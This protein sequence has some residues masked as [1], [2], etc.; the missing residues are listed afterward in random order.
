MIPESVRAS[1]I[2]GYAQQLHGSRRGSEPIESIWPPCGGNRFPV[3]E[4]PMFRLKSIRFISA[5]AALAMVVTSGCARL[6]PAGLA[7]LKP[8]LAEAV[9]PDRG[10][11]YV[12]FKISWPAES[13][14]PFWHLDALLAHKVAS[15][16]LDRF[17]S[18][19]ALWR[20]HRRAARDAVGHQ[21]S[22]IFYA[23]R[24]TADEVY[25]AFRE[26]SLLKRMKAA[27]WIAE[28][29]CDDT[30]SIRKAHIEDTSDPRWPSPVMKSWPFF[31]MGVSEMWLRLISEIA[32]QNPPGE[33]PASM[34]A[35]RE[36]YL[37]V[38]GRVEEIWR[39]ECGHA[40]LHHLN[41][42]FGY[43]PLM[44]GK[45]RWMQF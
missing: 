42:I 4:S 6:H 21:F 16:V 20:F 39:D 30:S 41:A 28:V 12:R 25:G 1:P 34:D 29:A 37:M 35:I 13:E 15:P 33:E 8:P 17:R 3:W 19:I 18:D 32:S 10:W 43:E 36:Y 40:L 11:W 22:F 14:E 44:V 26:D 23:T 2:G 24:K 31:I 5:M 45:G 9:Q 7:G 27:G 38:N